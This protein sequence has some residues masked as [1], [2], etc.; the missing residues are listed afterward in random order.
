MIPKKIISAQKSCFFTLLLATLS[1]LVGCNDKKMAETDKLQRPVVATTVK[2]EP[3]VQNR[4]FVG[5]VRPRIESDLGFRVTGKVNKRLVQAGD[6]VK[7]GQALAIL[8]L[9]DLSLQK[10]QSEAELKAATSSQT[11]ANAAYNRGVTLRAQGW[12]TQAQLDNLKATS[13][14]VNGR[15]LRDQQAVSLS[16]HALEYG[17][18]MSDVDGII[19][20]SFIEPGQIVAAG[21]P[22]LRVA[23][24]GAKEVL[25]AIPEAQIENLQKAKASVNFWGKDSTSYAATLRELSPSADSA[26]RTYQAKFTI[27]NAPETLDIGKTA[28][29]TLSDER[30]AQV[31]R[32][33]LS[34]LFNQGKGAALWVVDVKSGILSLK[35]VEIAGYEAQN[36][37]IKSG[38]VEGDMVV[39]LGVQKLDL[40]QKVKIVTGVF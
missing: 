16:A 35:H 33:P 5:I 34:S 11:Q 22:A 29:L 23:Q 15:V 37:L 31:A 21:V 1:I 14:E 39:T 17:T 2:Y 40:G 9:N 13:D 30:T 28:T 27:L 12:A 10:Q 36:V 32:L 19:T 20:A 6:T 26:T 18:L 38:V 24:A 25:V 3:L 7:A 4:S 8:D